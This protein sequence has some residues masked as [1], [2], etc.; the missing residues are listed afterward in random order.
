MKARLPLTEADRLRMLASYE[1][2]DTPSEA[3]FD[4]LAELAAQVCQTPTALI[5][6]IDDRRQWFKARVGLD[7]RE[8]HRDLA[9]CAHAILETDVLVVPDATRDPR[10]SVNA[11]V[12]GPPHIRF[13]AGAPVIVAEGHALGTVAVVDYEPRQPTDAQLEGLRALGR[14]VAA[15]LALRRRALEE[16]RRAATEAQQTADRRRAMLDSALDAIVGMDAEGR[17]TEFNP[18]A[19]R[20]FGYARE[21]AIGALLADL[22]VPVTLRE[23]HA[24]GLRRYLTSGDSAMLGRRVEAGAVRRDGTEFPVELS[25][26]RIGTAWPPMFTG[27]IRDI[28]DRK[29]LESQ[30]R[31]AQKME[32]IGQL[33]GG[34]AHD[35]NNILTVIQGHAALLLDADEEADRAA[36]S[37]RQI[38]EAA[39]RAARL[40]RQLLAFSR[41]QVLQ[42]TDV[43]VNDIVAGMTRMLDTLGKDLALRIEA[44]PALPLVRADVGMIEQVVL[45]LVVNARDAMPAGGEIRISTAIERID[46]DLARD[47]PEATAGTFVRLRVADS[48]TGIAPDAL[49]H[50]FEPFFT[51]KDVEKGTGLGLATVYG[52]VKQHRGWITVE[53][54]PGL[55]ATF[56]VYLPASD[57]PLEAPRSTPDERSTAAGAETVLIVE[58]EPAVRR[59]A[60]RILERNG[61]EVLEASDGRAAL[62]LWRDHG[63]LI[64]LVLTDMVM[65]KGVSG[66]DLAQRVLADRP[67]TRVI[68]TSG[69]SVDIAGTELH[70]SDSLTFLQKPYTA[71]ALL[72][73]VRARLDAR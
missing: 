68:V 10:F 20:M 9:F 28:T 50:I 53:S 49:P 19:E 12:T 23:R 5:T 37:V 63:H 54:A 40:T 21:E 36:D 17:L 15:Q 24:S 43:D 59:L 6:F 32:A 47:D 62:A 4:D 11:L 35:F 33:A 57:G 27:F 26:Q 56:D 70:Q 55:G 16:R 22:I 73:L 58:D 7:V 3:E 14:Q 38:A 52:I 34:V 31:H 61:Y 39:E 30:L 13:Y 46:E 29:Q 60:R 51:T 44:A 42:P 71:D 41:K 64:D 2:L 67:S 25:I 72:R 8:T 18:A 65:P 69:Y 45:N 66:M 1:V 48:G